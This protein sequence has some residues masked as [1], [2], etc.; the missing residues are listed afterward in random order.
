M[1]H[2]THHDE[3]DIT[4]LEQFRQSLKAE[5]EK[6]GIRVTL[7]G[8]VLKI[9]AR[10]LKKF[11]TM[12]EPRAS[13]RSRWMTPGVNRA[14]DAALHAWKLDKHRLPPVHYEA[15]MLL[16]EGATGKL[17]RLAVKRARSSA[18]G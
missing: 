16:R 7:L 10:A 12:K 9:L 18:S 3:A 4:E 14:T 5:A 15:R 17:R 8:F 1:P 11:P 6:E 2:V 13:A